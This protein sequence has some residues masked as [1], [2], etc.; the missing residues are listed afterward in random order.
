MNAQVDACETLNKPHMNEVL[1][2]FIDQEDLHR[3]EGAKG[4]QNLCQLVRAMGYKDPMYFGQFTPTA[5]LG[6]LICF[7]E[8]NP[9]AITAIHDFIARR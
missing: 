1:E 3:N 6:D 4:V 5:S 7:L 8:D 2:K 9:G